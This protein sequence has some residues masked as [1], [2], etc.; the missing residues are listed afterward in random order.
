M[1]DATAP[2]SRRRRMLVIALQTLVAVALVVA[3]WRL[4]DGPE[5][6]RLLRSARWD[7]IA[8]CAAALT[9]HTLIAAL[10][11]RRVARGLGIAIPVRE[12]VGAYYLSQLVNAVVPGG[13]VGDAGRAV[14]SRR[15]A[16]LGA[17]GLAVVLERLAGQYALLIVMGVAVATTIV[18]PGGVDWPSAA[19]PLLVVLIAGALGLP[20]L[21][22]GA[23]LL[24]GRV[25]A[26]AQDLT[27]A[28][29]SA[30]VDRGALVSVTGLS[31]GTTLCILVAFASAAAAVGAPLSLG[32]IVAVVPVVL[33][34]MLIPIT[35]GG[36]G[37]REG[38]AVALLPL[39]GVSASGALAASILFGL[40]A[41][42][43]TMPG[44][45]PLWG[46]RAARMHRT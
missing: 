10:R 15:P 27:A 36:W 8:L 23:T 35:V 33:L 43:A 2:A 26:R 20:A 28:I 44:I 32:G 25:G 17:A 45:V 16:G 19:V 42:A 12:A 40:V 41:L 31:L 7:F 1:N 34:A 30:V 3:L 5:T 22:A 4:V 24:P 39:A 21:I 9:A 13:V 38:A 37:L 14:R 6:G 29:R 11:W 18:I 46:R